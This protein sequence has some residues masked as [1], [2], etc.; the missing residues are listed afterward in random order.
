MKVTA[1]VGSYRR[2]GIVESA[3]DELLAAAQAAGAEVDKVN[4]L[5]QRV[6]FCTTA[7]PARARRGPAAAPAPCRTMSRRSSTGSRRARPSSWLPP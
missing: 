4:L 7:G 5:D 6:E 3:V 2:G 1:I